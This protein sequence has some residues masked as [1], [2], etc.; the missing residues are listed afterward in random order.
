M[1]SLLLLSLHIG[2]ALGASTSSFQVH[3]SFMCLYD[4]HSQ[5]SQVPQNLK[6]SGGYDHR[7]SLF[8]IPPYGGSISQKLYYADDNLCST[9][10]NAYKGFPER[11][12]NVPWVA[13]FILMVDR[14]G[15]T[16][17]QKVR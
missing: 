11:E 10:V 16:F 1:R 6:K 14:G 3:V 9:P 17:V 12:D 4:R 2:A 13:P 5:K 15:C 7:E 8:G